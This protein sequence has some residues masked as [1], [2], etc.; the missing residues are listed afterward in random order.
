MQVKAVLVCCKEPVTEHVDMGRFYEFIIE[1]SNINY[2]SVINKRAKK[3]NKD[4]P[5][6]W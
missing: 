5:I 6:E 3:Q 2:I 1:P 4:K